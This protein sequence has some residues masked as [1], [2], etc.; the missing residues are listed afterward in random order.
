MIARD[1]LALACL[2][3]VPSCSEDRPVG[4]QIPTYQED[5]APILMARCAGCHGKST[6]AAGWSA[7][8]FL[9]TIG[10]IAPSGAPATLPRDGSVPILAALDQD[11]HQGLLTAP[12]RELLTKW[13]SAGGPAFR[14]TVHAP[15]IVDPRSDGWHGSLL[16]DGRWS[17]MLDPN[18][19]NACGR[20][21][22]GTRSRPPGIAFAAP[23]ATACTTCHDQPV[24]IL[25]CPTCHGAGDRNY[26]PRDPCFFP[27]DS[28]RPGAHAAHVLPSQVRSIGL[29]CSTCHPMPPAQVIGG[30]HGN[31]T[32]DVIFDPMV[33]APGA[34]YDAATG[35]CTVSCHD[36][37]GAR[38]RP[39]WSDT[40]PLGCGD[41]HGSPPTG[42]F[43]G[44]CTNCHEEPNADG[45]ALSGALLHLNGKVDLGDGSGQCG[46][47]HGRG[48]DPWPATGAHP[49]HAS[50][51]LSDPVACSN[52]HVVPAT[53][54]DP[55]HLDGVV[56]VTLAG[57]AVA[58]DAGASWDGES[59]TS[60]ACHGAQLA[61]VPA[62]VPRWD[63]DSGAA[64]ACGACHPIPPSQHTSSTSCDRATC[65]G[66]EVVRN[67]QGV[68]SIAAA[69]RSL[70]IDG[71]IEVSP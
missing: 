53:V 67:A 20:C 33:V 1:A 45:T 27:A 57:L 37:G 42:H 15:G 44:P 46:A 51:T 8:S 13:V 65:H 58:R 21:H 39:L 18:D 9:E 24:G 66:R 32:V 3:L 31:G 6:P 60:V 47:C 68:P 5:V 4:A 14:S 26:P 22:D 56:H 48:D 41:C 49:S 11:P 64:S 40:T 28:V 62:V 30:T 2:S 16:R 35:G 70:H 55:T 59:C 17:S 61:D 63:D 34:S 43:P 25:A 50:P 7:T 38:P 54:M 12:E 69:G 23:G 19:S 10:C 71:I 36:V 52:C 29:P